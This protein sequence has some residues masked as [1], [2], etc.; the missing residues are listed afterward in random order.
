MEV[1]CH[2]ASGGG[3]YWFRPDAA[4]ADV[5]LVAAGDT[6]EQV[7]EAA[8][9]AANRTMLAAPECIEGRC[10]R[11]AALRAGTL[12]LL[13]FDWLGELVFWKDAASLVLGVRAVSVRTESDGFALEATLAGEVLE[14]QR[15]EPVVDVKGVTLHR[16]RV[17]RVATGW[18]AEA[19]LDI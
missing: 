4:L 12:E 3:R 16:L 2:Q 18:E 5:D 1:D 7:F 6:L 8:W 11:R 19:V 14:R 13:L 10:E 9:E 15:H 17:E